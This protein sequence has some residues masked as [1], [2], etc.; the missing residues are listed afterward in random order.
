MSGPMGEENDDHVKVVDATEPSPAASS[1][2]P[3]DSKGWDGKLR[4]D[5]NATIQNP[6]ALS[7][8]EY[9]DDENVLE[10]DEISADEGVFTT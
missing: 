1:P 3:R 4:V 7:D 10:G 9:S 2:G 6:E 8:P 5:R